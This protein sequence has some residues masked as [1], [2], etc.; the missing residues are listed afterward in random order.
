MFLEKMKIKNIFKDKRFL[1][2]EEAFATVGNLCAPLVWMSLGT[3][4]EGITGCC[5]GSYGKLCLLFFPM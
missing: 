4:L 1:K 5:F 2:D 3:I